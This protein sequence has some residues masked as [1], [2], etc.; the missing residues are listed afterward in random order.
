MWKKDDE[1]TA[2]PSAPSAPTTTQSATQAH[3][4][5]LPEG[6]RERAV[7]GASLAIVGEVT[8]GEDL[9][10]QGRVEGK[11]DLT[12]HAVTIGPSGRAIADIFAKAITI[13]GEV[14]GNLHA[15][16]QILI[17]RTGSV[18]GNLTAP[19]VMLEDGCK[20]K[21]NIDMEPLTKDRAK[22]STA[23]LPSATPIALPASP[24]ALK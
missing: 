16:E 8:G 4:T 17:R 10:V 2:R 11:I 20:F 24:A 18:H 22:T 9:V 19:R 12:Q 5:A 1:P 6:P 3:V 23:P 15:A 7:L 13:E 21:G 14:K